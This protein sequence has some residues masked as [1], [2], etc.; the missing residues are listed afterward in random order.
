MTKKKEVKQPEMEPVPVPEKEKTGAKNNPVLDDLSELDALIEAETEETGPD[1]NPVEDE[2]ADKVAIAEQKQKEA[3]AVGQSMVAVAVIG[4][5]I[6]LVRPDLTV[7]EAQKKQVQEKLAPVLLKYSTG[8]VPPWLLKY[9]EELELAGVLGMVGFS[10]YQQVKAEEAAN[11][12]SGGEDGK[13]SESE[14]S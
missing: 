5:V 10:M 7:S 14:T 4:Q 13:Q 9:R 2:E 6:E 3:A 8:G 1:Y 11:D 12:Q